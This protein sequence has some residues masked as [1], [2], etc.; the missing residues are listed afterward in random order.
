MPEKPN[1]RTPQ[2]T[3]QAEETR[4][5][6]E[7][8]AI[9]RQSNVLPMDA[10]RNEGRFYGQLFQGKGPLNGVQRIGCFLVGSLFV[11]SA[12]SIIIGAFPRFFSVIGLRSQLISDK[13]ISMAYLPFAALSLFLG[14]R[15][16]G[17]AIT[18]RRRKP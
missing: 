13:S 3:E 18:P 2:E 17:T 4:R 16:I 15:I 8:D 7:A 10:A 12:V 1:H 5:R 6:F 9:S 14:L 11:L